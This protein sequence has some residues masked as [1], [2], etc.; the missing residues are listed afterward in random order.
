MAK[1]G[2]SGKSKSASLEE[3]TNSLSDSVNDSGISVSSESSNQDSEK[4]TFYLLS[5]AEHYIGG[6]HHDVLYEAHKDRLLTTVILQNPGGSGIKG[7]FTT[8]EAIKAFL[9]G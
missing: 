1:T 3:R 5:V 6:A 7:L 2:N 4:T 8:E 9:G